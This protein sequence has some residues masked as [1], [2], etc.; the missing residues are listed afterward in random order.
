MNR[1]QLLPIILLFA[2]LYT[3]CKKPA[4]PPPTIVICLGPGFPADDEGVKNSIASFI[5]NLP[6]R[7][8]TAEN[9]DKL[10]QTITDRC[11]VVAKVL[12]FN[13]IKTFPSMTEVVISFPNSTQQ[14][15]VDISYTSSNEMKVVNV[16]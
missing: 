5:N 9:L 14:K 2:C 7:Q 1:Y 11:S 3:G 16:H 13:C 4:D 15:V 10:A 12:C 8:Y 6:S